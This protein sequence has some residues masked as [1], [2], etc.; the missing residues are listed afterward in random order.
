MGTIVARPRKD[1]TMGYTAQIKIKRGGKVVFSQAQTFDREAAARVWMKRK[2]RDLEKPGAIEAA[3]RASAGT[4]AD[5]IDSYLKDSRKEIGRTKAQVLRAIK[6]YDIATRDCDRI[7]SEDVVAFARELGRN[8]QPQTVQNYLSHLAAVFAVARS[9]W[10]YPI[11]RTVM[12]EAAEACKRLGLTAR[13]RWRERRPTVDE[14]EKIMAHFVERSHRRPRCLPMHK[15]IA[16]AVFSTRR[17][18]EILRIRWADLE[19][20]RVLVRDMKN[21]GEKAGNHVWCQLVPEAEEIARAMPRIDDRIFPYSPDAVSKA[22]TE[23][24]KLLEI[25]DLHFHDLRHEG[26][27]RLFELGWSIPQVATVTGHRSW[28]SLQR[29]S[30]I[31]QTGDKL[32]RWKW[33]VACGMQE[34]RE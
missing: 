10:G 7:R 12:D 11:E 23:G 6:S 19:E 3:A 2:E 25:E 27:S 17:Q 8:R 15:V 9:A 28:Q 18:E 32:A 24:C 34:P 33:R 14:L 22:F 31:R 13:S 5:A 16:F 21:P 30:H 26:T 20:G 4:L 1:G 29:Y